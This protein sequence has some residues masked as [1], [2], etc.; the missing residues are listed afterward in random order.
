MIW[1]M[2]TL[3]L[4]TTK[5]VNIDV[6]DRDNDSIAIRLV[7]SAPAQAL[8][9]G[10]L[11]SKQVQLLV[12][13]IDQR[14]AMQQM[15]ELV[16]QYKDLQR[17]PHLTYNNKYKMVSAD[18]YTEPNFV[19]LIDNRYYVYTAILQFEMERMIF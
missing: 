15:E 12:K 14:N 5:K 18:V 1:L 6:L 4:N 8:Y 10:E 7:P 13:G 3:M 2:E 9:I 16:E 11:S 19:D 17:K